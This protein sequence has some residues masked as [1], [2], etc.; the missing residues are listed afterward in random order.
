MRD[1]ISPNQRLSITLRFLATGNSFSDLKFI[2]AISERAIGRI[3]METC[4]E[5]SKIL[6]DNIK[7]NKTN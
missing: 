2:S 6:K 7:V 1:A 5:I 3:V 4:E